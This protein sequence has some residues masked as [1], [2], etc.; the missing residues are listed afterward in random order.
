[1]IGLSVCCHDWSVCVLSWLACLCVVMIG[2]SV[3][4]VRAAGNLRQEAVARSEAATTPRTPRT[5]R[6]DTATTPRSAVDSYTPFSQSEAVSTHISASETEQKRSGGTESTS[7]SRTIRTRSSHDS[8]SSIAE[9]IPDGSYTHKEASPSPDKRMDSSDDTIIN[10]SVNEEDET[11]VRS[12]G[13]KSPVG[14]LLPPGNSPL[15]QPWSHKTGSESESE[16]SVSHTGQ[17]SFR[18][19]RW[20]GCALCV[21]VLW[22]PARWV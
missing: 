4:S 22:D 3:L 16:E 10:S 19:Q 6:T 17:M 12:K 5:A 7:R 11:E 15:P 14:R 2:L 21:A 20:L 8:E 1:M 13:K 9:D 18:G